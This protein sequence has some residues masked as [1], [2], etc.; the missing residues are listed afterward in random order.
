[1]RNVRCSIAV[2]CN[3]IH[4]TESSTSSEFDVDTNKPAI[5]M[6]HT[7][8]R[9]YPRACLMAATQSIARIVLAD[10]KPI[11]PHGY[12]K[13]KC[14]HNT[15]AVQHPWQKCK[16]SRRASFDVSCITKYQL[17]YNALHLKKYCASIS[18]RL[19]LRYFNTAASPTS[20]PSTVGR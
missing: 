1:M 12:T 15:D 3:V 20:K 16:T 6:H 19:A 18:L 9:N 14:F 4:H 17:L 10:Q 8:H 11:V 5:I 7:C 2:L 13:T